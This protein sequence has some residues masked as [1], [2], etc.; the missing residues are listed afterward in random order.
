VASPLAAPA[1]TPAQR[2]ADHLA[3]HVTSPVLCYSQRLQLLRAPGASASALR[4]QPADRRNAGA[5][6]AR[7]LP[8]RRPL[9]TR[10]G[11]ALVSRVTVF[12]LVQG[13]VALGAWWTLFR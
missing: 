3:E 1:G 7:A 2:F 11:G 13:A 4:G 12:L 9:A 8:T 5:A 6:D 10:R